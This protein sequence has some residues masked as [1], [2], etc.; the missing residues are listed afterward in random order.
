MKR[1]IPKIKILEVRELRLNPTL[2][3][4]HQKIIGHL[5]LDAKYKRY[6]LD[7]TIGRRMAK[8]EILAVDELD[9][10]HTASIQVVSGWKLNM[11]MNRYD[12]RK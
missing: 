11:G 8:G 9:A 2:Q 1:K 7:F 10:W 12:R 5:G 4:V 3:A 6:I